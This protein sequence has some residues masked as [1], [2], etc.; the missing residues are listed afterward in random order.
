ML[1][2]LYH[3]IPFKKSKIKSAFPLFNLFFLTLLDLFFENVCK[4]PCISS[5]LLLLLPVLMYIVVCVVSGGL[6]LSL[7]GILFSSVL[8]FLNFLRYLHPF[9]QIFPV[10]ITHSIIHFLSIFLHLINKYLEIYRSSCLSP[11]YTIGDISQTS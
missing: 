11:H 6:S 5:R 7:F 2:F 9:L 1:I 10:I 4:K 8:Y 3:Q